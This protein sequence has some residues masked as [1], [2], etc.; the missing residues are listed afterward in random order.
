MYADFL[1]KQYTIT[2]IF[3]YG[4]LAFWALSDIRIEVLPLKL[5]LLFG[6]KKICISR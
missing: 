1:R 4:V 3:I 2:L 6:V 5:G